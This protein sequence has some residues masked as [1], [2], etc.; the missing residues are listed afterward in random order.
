MSANSHGEEGESL[1]LVTGLCAFMLWGLVPLYWKTLQKV[2]AAEILA[3]RLLWS[4]AFSLLLIAWQGRWSEVT[5]ALLSRKQVAFAAASGAAIGLNWFIFIWAVNSGQVV[6]TSLGYFITPLLNVLLGALL[7]RERLRPMQ[8]VAIA[9]AGVGVLYLT[10]GYGSLSW[11]AMSLC[12]SFTIYGLLRKA[13]GVESLPG[14]FLESAAILPVGA[15]YFVHLVQ[16]GRSSFTPDVPAVALLL[17]GGGIV[18]AIPL[19]CF[20]HAARN[21]KLS[22]LGL[23]QYLSPTITFILGVALYRE[24]F[25]RQ[26]LITFACIWAGL[27]IYT[28]EARWHATAAPPPERPPE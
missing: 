5:Q 4:F 10:L 25:T 14:L 24:P 22:T 8:W 26:H 15:I 3:H 9:L 11:I 17:A 16:V 27:A 18:T 6:Q 21:L 19:L 7:F 20:A 2:P 12:I 23:L 13:S 28:I 1:G